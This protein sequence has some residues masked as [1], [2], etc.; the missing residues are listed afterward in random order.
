MNPVVVAYP[1]TG[2]KIITDIVFNYSKQYF[3]SERCLQEFLLPAWYR[4]DNFVFEDNHILGEYK[5]LPKELWETNKNI[6][7][8]NEVIEE[9]IS[10]LKQNPKYVFK[11]MVNPRLPESTYEFCLNNFDCIFVERKDIVRSF[12]SFFFLAE[13]QHHHEIDAK[14]LYKSETKI[15]FYEKLANTWVWDYSKFCELKNKVKNKKE[16]TYEDVLVNGQVSENL[17]LN[18]LN[19]DIDNNFVPTQL[20]TI[21]T[22]Y[23]DENLLSYFLN[24]DDVIN[25][26]KKNH[27]IFK[28]I[29]F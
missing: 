18:K 10:W 6:R 11:L 17:V 19:W 15:Q 4:V 27:Y 28:E 21:P 9:R 23:E 12:L 5:N 8:I 22:P 14:K 1:R 7:P 20:T 29:N 3:G 13:T 2:S 25:F 16:I 24:P 26:I